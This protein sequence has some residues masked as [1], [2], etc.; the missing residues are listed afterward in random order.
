MVYNV[1]ASCWL[2]AVE[3][4]CVFSGNADRHHYETFAKA[5]KHGRLMH[6]DSAKRYVSCFT[7]HATR[8]CV[9]AMAA[10]AIYSFPHSTHQSLCEVA[11]DQ[12]LG[13]RLC[14]GGC[15]VKYIVVVV[16]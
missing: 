6:I 3:R 15:V 2:L 1:A 9:H 12:S 11:R 14:Q 8:T 7:L 16:H 4:L 13:K 5:E 10:M